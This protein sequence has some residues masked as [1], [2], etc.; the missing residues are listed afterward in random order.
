MFRRFYCLLSIMLL[1]GQ[2]LANDK[3]VLQ[4][5]W[6]HEFQFAGYY[7]AQWQ[8]YYD[9]VGL[10]V[11]IRSAIRA[12]KSIITTSAEIQSGRAQ[13][14]VG[15][16]DILMSI[17]HGLEPVVLAPIFQRSPLAL[18]SLKHTDIST[19]RKISKLRI[20][21]TGSGGT[22]TEIEALFRSHGYDLSKIH[23][24]DLP[25]TLDVLIADKA[26]VIATYSVSA[27]FEAK[28]K[29][30]ELNEFHPA[31]FGMA[32][33]G[34]T[35]YTSY[36]YSQS[37]PDIVDKFTKASIKGWLYA[38]ENK[39]EIA[40]NISERYKR[41]LFTYENSYGYNLAFTEHIDSLIRYPEI[42]IGH[43]NKDRWFNMNERLRSL[44]LVRSHLSNNHFYVESTKNLTISQ[45]R[46]LAFLT[47]ALFLPFIFFFWYRR[48]KILTIATMLTALLILEYQLEKILLIEQV[49]NE[50]ED[51]VRTL[52]SV[53]A[54]LQGNLQTN[55]SML[56]GF[57]AYI[58]ATPNLSYE[59]FNHYAEELFK[60]EPML[61]NFAAAKD[62]K[63]NYV[64]PIEGNEQV[65]GLDYRKNP[66]QL[67]MVLQVVNSG[68]I[69][70]VGPVN[71]VQGGT[72]F[73]GRAPIVTGDGDLWGIISAPLD[74][75]LLYRFS[76]LEKK[77][78]G[79]NL[80]IRSYDA[81]GN[82]EKVFYGDKK[83]FDDANRLQSIISVG[84]GSWHIAA[85]PKFKK[86][87]LPNNIYSLRIYFVIIGLLLSIFA[88]FR[89]Q[90]EFE[91]GILVQKIKDDKKLLESVGSVARIGGFKLDINLCYVNWSEQSSLLLDRPIEFVPNNLSE[92][93]HYFSESD[94][95]LLRT[96]SLE[97]VE[98]S[99]AFDIEIQLVSKGSSYQWLRVMSD[100]SIFENTI[101]GTIQDVTDK[102][103]SAK[104]I[105]HQA[106]YDNLTG[107]P[108]RILYHDRLVKS[109]ENAHR[110]KQKVAVLFIDLDR[111]KPIND[112]HGHQAGDR[113]LIETAFRIKQ[114]LRESD[115]V[116]RLSGDEFAVILNNVPQYSHVSKI[117]EQILENMQK[118]YLLGDISVYLSASIGM[119][120]YPNDADDADS[121]LRKA[122]QAM[123]EV[124]ASGRNG[125]QFYTTEMQLKSEYRH[126]L[127]NHLI[128]AVNNRSLMPYFQ[129]IFDL[130]T[131]QIQKCETLARWRKSD[132]EFVPP[133]DFINL[134]EETGLINKIDLFMLEESA[135]AL[136]DIAPNIELSINISPRLFH[137]KDYALEKW[138][139]CIKTMSQS[140]N[141]TVEITERLLTD[142]SERA[143]IVLN[144]LKEYGVKIAI[145]DFGTGY[146]SLSYLM[147]YPVDLI[148]IDRAFVKEIG[149]DSSSEALI[150]TILA[151]AN[152]LDIKV[153]A[154]GIETIEQLNYLRKNHCQFGQGYYLGKPMGIEDFDQFCQK[155]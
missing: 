12:D 141:I 77:K 90:Q 26:D 96:K 113:L 145:D 80:A 114:S 98:N 38:L 23:F 134:A 106:T 6:E 52:N 3:V 2:L 93:E 155:Q 29:D 40:K 116:S 100:G 124:K 43:I 8:G 9:D 66:A 108:N 25:V 11:E 109:I 34:D 111:F 47:I 130:E 126:D 107:L 54:K 72:A 61:I 128:V 85:T 31:D 22:K 58:S 148:K 87:F 1:S 56:T 36:T 59:D 121:L 120:I 103:L 28:E 18:F 53:S 15:T 110:N 132:G 119:A 32:F 39:T 74:T 46:I 137:T 151:M 44:G 14:A 150:E 123:Y 153:V 82:E 4:L 37:D 139:N 65:I 143:L 142:D 48:Y 19:L 122:D 102:I 136:I 67:P 70:M 27:N 33:Y 17:D 144:Q 94:Y 49:K 68:L 20:V 105:E 131:N 42:P 133:I 55:L 104:L 24:V 51:I 138:T 75:E 73:I 95:S 78:K 60:K 88:W 91:K 99:E 152:R 71:L 45:Q 57:A 13:F 146:S 64:Y 89:F 63:V 125:C 16:L 50:K 149:T 115:T 30:V 84:G 81:L 147:K 10:D 35:L 79:I 86:D 41:Q 83:V 62:L 97:A 7:A 140:I 135:S 5:K 112:N 21:T 127:L 101:T 118:A 76:E 92:L 154:E 129:P 117:A 69:Q